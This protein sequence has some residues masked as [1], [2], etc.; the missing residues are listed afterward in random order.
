MFYAKDPELASYIN[1]AHAGGAIFEIPR[2]F[3]GSYL[4]VVNANVA[5]GKTDAFI[6]Q[7]INATINVDTS[8]ATLTDLEVI[9]E[10]K[11]GN[12]RD[13]WWNAEN[14]N[15]IQVYTNLDSTLVSLKGNT[16]K[17][18]VPTF[19]YGTEGFTEN[20]D[21]KAI[22]AS[23]I[24]VP[25]FNAWTMRAFEKSVFATWFNTPGGKKKTLTM[26]Y[27]TDNTS[28]SLPAD[29]IVYTFIYERQSGVRSN[30]SVR[31][32]API[33]FIWA[34][35]GTPNYSYTNNDPEGRVMISLTLKK[36]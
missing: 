12:E 21:L 35:S 31:I 30:I 7:S 15:F 9:R 6:A 5:G 3:F 25:E 16:I 24:S 19:N 4:A 20:E 14:K 23:R 10:H 27:H 36:Q 29:G 28:G 18:I 33:G 17:K 26:R 22:D 32:S 2:R 11:G 1:E 13:P 34:E 8:G